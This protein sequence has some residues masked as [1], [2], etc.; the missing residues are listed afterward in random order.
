MSISILKINVNIESYV[1]L[2]QLF[3]ICNYLLKFD[4]VITIEFAIVIA[5]EF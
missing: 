5:I 2:R 1:K 4:I 3:G